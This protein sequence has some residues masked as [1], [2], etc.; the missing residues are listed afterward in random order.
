MKYRKWIYPGLGVKR[1]ALLLIFSFIL[2]S[3]GIS[4]FLD[5]HQLGYNLKTIIIKFF[6]PL[7]KDNCDFIEII[8]AIIL[9][10]LGLVGVNYGLRGII[11]GLYR[12][13]KENKYINRMYKENILEKGPSVVTLGGGTGLSNLLRGLKHYTSNITAIV[14]VADDGGSSGKLREELGILPPGDIRNC[15]VALADAEPLMQDLFQ[16]RF[17]SEG[18]LVGHS[19][20]NLFRAS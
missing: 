5:Y 10:V 8:I 19:F 1:W 6:S 15:L 3:T 20:G 2:I 14:T 17:S 9:I 7:F 11:K 4:I 13:G 12:T 18:H 16:Y